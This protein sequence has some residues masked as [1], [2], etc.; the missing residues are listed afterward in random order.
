MLVILL[1]LLTFASA[2][3]QCSDARDTPPV[4]DCGLSSYDFIVAGGGMMYLFPSLLNSLTDCFITGTAGA[5][6]AARLANTNE[7]VINYLII[8]HL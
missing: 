6:V 4:L 2:T 8:A 3:Q 1:A 5:I 7:N